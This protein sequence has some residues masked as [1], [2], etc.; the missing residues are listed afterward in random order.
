MKAVREGITI[1][2]VEGTV[3]EAGVADP[4][5]AELRLRPDALVKDVR[6][7]PPDGEKETCRSAL[8]PDLDAEL[9]AL[10]L[11][12]NLDSNF[13]AADAFGA[14][15]PRRRLGSAPLGDPLGAGASSAD[16]FLFSS[17]ILRW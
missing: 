9:L 4:S 10:D 8:V 14:S 3:G 13:E 1:G 11:L 16:L 17:M 2:A 7:V 15:E 6:E 12:P 5:M